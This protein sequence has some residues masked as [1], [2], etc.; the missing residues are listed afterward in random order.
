MTDLTLCA[1]SS[2]TKRGSCHRYQAPVGDYQK[3]EMFKE[4]AKGK[5]DSYIYEPGTMDD[6]PA[7]V[8]W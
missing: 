7:K 8:E 1:N 6:E 2:C 4:C 3:V 5:F